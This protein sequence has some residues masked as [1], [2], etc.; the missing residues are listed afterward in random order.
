M[1]ACGCCG[2]RGHTY[3]VLNVL[4]RRHKALPIASTIVTQ[5]SLTKSCIT[6]IFIRYACHVITCCDLFF[7][8]TGVGSPASVSSLPRLSIT[9][10][11]YI[12]RRLYSITSLPMFKSLRVLT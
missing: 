6:V 9:Q 11:T 10:S 4:S 1:C 8:C 7:I 12:K 2:L 5:L 3:H